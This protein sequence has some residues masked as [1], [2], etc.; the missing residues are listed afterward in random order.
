VVVSA[1]HMDLDPEIFGPILGAA[2]MRVK[3]QYQNFWSSP[4]GIR[5][6]ESHLRDDR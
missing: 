1:D 4:R 6:V 3:L 2:V 5:E